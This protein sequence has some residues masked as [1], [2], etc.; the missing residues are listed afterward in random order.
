MRYNKLPV[1]LQAVSLE[2]RAFVGHQSA[3]TLPYLTVSYYIQKP[4]NCTLWSLSF[5]MATIL[6]YIYMFMDVY[7]KSFLILWRRVSLG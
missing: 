7:G 3:V 5:P 6:I 4:V 2:L 1:G